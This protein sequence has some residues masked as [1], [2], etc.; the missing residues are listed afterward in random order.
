MDR[1]VEVLSLINVDANM[2]VDFNYHE[3]CEYVCVCG[4]KIL[5]GYSTEVYSDVLVDIWY[6]TN[7]GRWSAS[8]MLSGHLTILPKLN[9][10][11][12]DDTLGM[13]IVNTA[14]HI[15]FTCWLSSYDTKE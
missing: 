15:D 7:L 5:C 9:V 12:E 1:I 2:I 10:L 8:V 13:D 3:I 4:Y 14:P 11:F 6:I